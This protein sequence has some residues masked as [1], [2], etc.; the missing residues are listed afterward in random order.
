MVLAMKTMK[1]V[2]AMKASKANGV[3]KVI[4]YLHLGLGLKIGQCYKASYLRTLCRGSRSKVKKLEEFMKDPTYLRPGGRVCVTAKG[5]CM[6]LMVF[7]GS[8]GMEK[9]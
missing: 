3:F 4:K 1:A 9:T 8:Q 6:K 7:N 2:K 5:P